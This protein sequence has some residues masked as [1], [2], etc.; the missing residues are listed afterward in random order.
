MSS[1][2]HYSNSKAVHLLVLH[3]RRLAVHS[4]TGEYV[5]YHGVNVIT[6]ITVEK[7]DIGDQYRLTKVYE[8]KLQRTACNMVHGPF[9]GPKGEIHLL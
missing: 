9:G 8:H 7:T 6:M 4:L 1:L 5:Y 3:P 2:N